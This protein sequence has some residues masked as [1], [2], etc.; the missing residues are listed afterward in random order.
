MVSL[1]DE[2]NDQ[3]W[4]WSDKKILNLPNNGVSPEQLIE[5]QLS[6]F[7]PI[8]EHVKTIE[9]KSLD[10]TTIK[11]YVWN[12]YHIF[13]GKKESFTIYAGYKPEAMWGPYLGKVFFISRTGLIDT[14]G[15]TESDIIKIAKHL[16]T[17]IKKPRESIVDSILNGKSRKEKIEANKRVEKNIKSYTATFW[18]DFDKEQANKD[19][20]RKEM[21]KVLQKMNWEFQRWA[22]WIEINKKVKESPV[23]WNVPTT[24]TKN[25]DLTDSRF[26]STQ[27]LFLIYSS[28]IEMINTRTRALLWYNSGQNYT[29]C[30]YATGD[31]EKV[32][33]CYMDN[34]KD[35]VTVKAFEIASGKEKWATSLKG[36]V[37]I[38]WLPVE[39]SGNLVAVQKE[40]NKT[41]M[42]A[43]DSK[44]GTKL[45]E[46][47][48]K[49]SA[50][51]HTPPP[52]VQVGDNIVTFSDGIEAIS[53]DK[54]ITI[55]RNGDLRLDDHCP[56]PQISNDTIIILDK[57]NSLTWLDSKT[58]QRINTINVRSSSEY[59]NIYPVRGRIYLRGKLNNSESSKVYFL[60]AIKNPSGESLWSYLDSLITVSNLI[61]DNHKVFAATWKGPIAIDWKSGLPL[62]STEISGVGMTYPVSIRKFGDTIVYIGEMLVAGVNGMTGAILFRQAF[63]PV[64]QTRNLDAID[65]Q[66]QQLAEYLKHFG[67]SGR[68]GVTFDFSGYSDLFFSSSKASQ[69]RSSNL[70]RLS[71]E[72]Y[73]KYKSSGS[74]AEYSKSEI[75]YGQSRIESSFAG[76]QISISMMFM[77][78]GNAATAIAKFTEPERNRLTGLIKIREG[79]VKIYDR[80]QFGDYVIRL[81]EE[82][83]SSCVAVVNLPTGKVTSWLRSNRV[84]KEEIILNPEQGEFY[85]HELRLV[86]ELEKDFGNANDNTAAH[87]Y[88][89]VA[90]PLEQ[91]K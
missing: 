1:C 18:S 57:N 64:S 69:E 45:W 58:G 30:F 65:P 80:Q 54:G 86:P 29:E 38:G 2:N 88:Y 47:T 48:I 85:Y 70:A 60:D 73:R 31:E 62:F 33:C 39:R 72:S 3:I 32:I 4:L 22:G 15:K 61:D 87:A 9:I 16:Q 83:D 13:N 14:T 78:I 91:N 74:S 42:T 23:S 8:H 43:L 35:Y 81:M 59:T 12:A 89:L 19:S 75:A 26:V 49:H 37:P 44:T 53:L 24:A 84:K 76:A 50:G 5:D 28:R 51:F 82:G 20:I 67:T 40:E 21:E 11:M 27:Y 17:C 90:V 34:G 10:K 56:S 46:T 36:D 68:K 79:L 55:W 52:P 25:I 71:E 7:A 63:N 66:C 6:R 77:T 41:H